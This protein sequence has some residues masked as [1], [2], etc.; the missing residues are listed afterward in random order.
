M[1]GGL[2]WM[3]EVMRGGDSTKSSNEQ[4]LERVDGAHATGPNRV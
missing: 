2:M 4:K 3:V 1:Y